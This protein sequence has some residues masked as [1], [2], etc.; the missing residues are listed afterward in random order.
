MA[1]KLISSV[2]LALRLNSFDVP[3]KSPGTR[4][5]QKKRSSKP[6][7]NTNNLIR[8]LIVQEMGFGFIVRWDRRVL[9][10]YSDGRRRNLPANRLVKLIERGFTIPVTKGTPDG[11]AVRRFFAY[12]NIFI[13]ST[14]TGIRVPPRPFYT[15]TV[16]LFIRQFSGISGVQI[17]KIGDSVHIRV[18]PVNTGISR[19]APARTPLPRISSRPR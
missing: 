5:I 9:L 7:V 4:K 8:H 18:V 1:Y 13:K 16:N 14:K 2:R 17:R 3:K 11:D 10:S 6:L 19:A 15:N 12:H